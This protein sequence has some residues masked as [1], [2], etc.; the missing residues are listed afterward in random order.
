MSP[1]GEDKDD[2]ADS[3]VS[4]SSMIGETGDVREE[5]M[6]Y[7]TNSKVE[8]ILATLSTESLNSEGIQK[9]QRI[10]QRL[11]KADEIQNKELDDISLLGGLNSEGLDKRL[12]CRK[13][14]SRHLD[15]SESEELEEHIMTRKLMKTPSV[16]DLL[17]T[18]SSS[19]N[20]S[21]SEP[22]REDLSI[23]DN[24]PTMKTTAVND[25]KM[26]LS[27]TSNSP[28]T[29]TSK[30]GM[31]EISNEITRNDIV[32][33]ENLKE[34]SNRGRGTMMDA[35]L[36]HIAN[37]TSILS[38][39]Q[40]AQPTSSL[41]KSNGSLH[42]TFGGTCVY[43][44]D[45]NTFNANNL[46]A[47]GPINLLLF[48]ETCL[49]GAQCT[50]NHVQN[51]FLSTEKLGVMSSHNFSDRGITDD[52]LRG[53]NITCYDNSEESKTTFLNN[54][55]KIRLIGF[56]SNAFMIDENPTHP[57]EYNGI[58]YSV[59]YVEIEKEPLTTD[60]FINKYSLDTCRSKINLDADKIVLR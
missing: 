37:T 40:T 16:V 56:N 54:H 50:T 45:M 42:I 18:S 28:P 1:N 34:T 4:D 33:S 47:T 5:K 10:R 24:G 51:I 35:Q 14:N 30:G 59:I 3:G 36:S 57:P 48:R 21:D 29:A 27:N 17:Q 13:I 58:H 44:A 55:I 25:D 43:T 12:L 31:A 38:S 41:N 6:I 15:D 22:S 60:I 19:K 53:M 2:D 11:S 9:R 52:I 32:L 8:S 49:F 39:L 46:A 20:E 26:S 7:T 23:E